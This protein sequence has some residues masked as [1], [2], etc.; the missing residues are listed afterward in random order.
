MGDEIFEVL[1]IRNMLSQIA[2][3]LGLRPS[4]LFSTRA[5][6]FT[7]GRGE[8][9]QQDGEPWK[10]DTAC[11]V[12]IELQ[13]QQTMLRAPKSEEGQWHG[14][15]QPAFWEIADA[16]SGSLSVREIESP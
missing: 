4:Y 10:M 7:V 12:L 5:L 8:F 11:D 1:S 16:R 15:I 3:F 14:H 2:L 13:N 6:A 9:M